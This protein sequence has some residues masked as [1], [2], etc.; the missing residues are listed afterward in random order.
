MSDDTTVPRGLGSWIQS[1]QNP[2][3]GETRSERVRKTDGVGILNSSHMQIQFRPVQMKKKKKKNNNNNKKK[4]STPL[5]PPK[6][7]DR[8]LKMATRTGSSYGVVA[9]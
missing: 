9:E 5:T 8:D 1:A 6:R 2:P 4:C 3:K 7:L